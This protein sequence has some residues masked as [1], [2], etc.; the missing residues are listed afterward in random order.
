MPRLGELELT[1]AAREAA[2]NW[3]DFDCFAWFRQ[4]ELKRPDDWAIFYTHNRDSGLL[5]QSNAAVIA[6]AMQPFAEGNDP[7]VV[8]ESHHH[9]AVG[10]VDGFSLRVFKRGRIT[11]AFKVYHEL[12]QQMA[13]Y[14]ILDETD[15]SER[16]YQAS[17]EN[18]D[19][20]AWNLKREFDLPS[21][22]Q[23]S[24]FE[25]LWQNRETALENTDDQGGWPDDDD[26]EAA[27]AALGFQRAA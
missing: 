19:L 17:Y 3:Q 14:P 10:H 27:F 18:I 23:S 11:K 13:D 1:D 24:V 9:W 21:D 26:L 22:W 4:R 16:E 5:D 20:A 8:F 15:Y 7:D 2:G 25:W 6:K 12:A